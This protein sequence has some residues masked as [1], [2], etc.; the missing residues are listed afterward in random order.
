MAATMTDDGR[1]DGVMMAASILALPLL[2]VC[3]CALLRA[4]VLFSGASVLFSVLLCSSPGFCALL[5]AFVLFSG[6]LCACLRFSGPWLLSGPSSVLLSRRCTFV[7]RVLRSCDVVCT[8]VCAL[9][10][11]LFDYAAAE[12]HGAAA[13]VRS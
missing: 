11:L 9:D 13:P 10:A 4:F 12:T 7:R 1:D 6:L 3:F 8:V 2:C 5:R